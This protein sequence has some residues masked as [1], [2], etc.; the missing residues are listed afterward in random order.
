MKYNEPTKSEKIKEDALGLGNTNFTKEE[1]EAIKEL[2]Q[3]PEFKRFEEIVEQGIVRTAIALMS[4]KG[5]DEEIVQ[6]LYYFKG[7]YGALSYI[8]NVINNKAN[9]IK[10]KGKEN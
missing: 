4:S 7:R 6:Q 2:V 5:S 1:K 3:A 10:Q 9:A 8:K